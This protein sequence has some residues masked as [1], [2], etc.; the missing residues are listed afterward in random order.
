M[1]KGQY[2]FAQLMSLI[3]PKEFTTCVDKYKGNYRVRTFKCW[4]QFLCMSFGQLTHRESLRDI[5]ICLQA[6]QNKLYHL[7]ITNGVRKSTLADANETRDWRIYAEFAQI[8]ITQARQSYGPFHETSI[9]L[10]NVVYALDAT[11]IE[12]CLSVFWWAKFRK[13]K[14]ASKLHTLLDVKCE[15]PCF[16]HITDGLTHDVNVLDILEFEPAAFYVMDRGYIENRKLYNS[17]LS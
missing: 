4:Q 9:E 16:I 10:D 5:V 12:L 8:L 14:A 1:N 2:V 3:N 13:H 7:G 11:I 15:I 6:Q 17:V